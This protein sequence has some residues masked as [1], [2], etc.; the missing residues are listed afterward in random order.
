MQDWPEPVLPV[1]CNITP[2]FLHVMRF[3]YIVDQR[4]TSPY[5]L[6]RFSNGSLVA[7]YTTRC[8]ETV[9]LVISFVDKGDMEIMSF[10]LT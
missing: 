1:F 7:F 4:V 9:G 2:L 3:W 8:R 5:F 6:L 10:L